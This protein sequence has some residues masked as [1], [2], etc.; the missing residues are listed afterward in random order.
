VSPELAIVAT[1]ARRYKPAMP[2]ARLP[3]TMLVVSIAVGAAS[4]L[5]PAAAAALVNGAPSLVLGVSGRYTVA[6]RTEHVAVIEDGK[7][8]DVPITN[9]PIGTATT[10]AYFDAAVGIATYADAGDGDNH[11]LVATQEQALHDIS[12]GK[13]SLHDDIVA[14]FPGKILS[15]AG[16]YSPDDG[17]QHAIVLFQGGYISDVSWTIGH[18]NVRRDGLATISS[19]VGVGAFYA[20]DDHTRI[21][22]VAEIG[23]RLHEIYYKPGVAPHDSIIATLNET[24]VA[25]ASVFTNDDKYRHA[26]VS[27]L[28]GNVYD[29]FY[30]PCCGIQQRVLATVP[31]TVRLGA[32]ATPDNYRHVFAGT[33]VGEIRELY[34]NRNN[35]SV[36]VARERLAPNAAWLEDVSPNEANAKRTSLQYPSGRMVGVAGDG[37][38]IYGVSPGAGVW[39]SVGGGPFAQ[40]RASPRYSA[41]IASDP[42]DVRHVFVGERNGLAID[43]RAENTGL[44]ESSDG[45]T[46]FHIAFDAATLPECGKTRVITNVAFSRNHSVF[47]TTAC[48]VVRRKDGESAFSRVLSSPQGATWPVF[49]VLSFSEKFAGPRRVW[50]RTQD[51]VYVSEKDGDA[52]SW[53]AFP[54]QK[55]YPPLTADLG[56][57]P[58]DSLSLATADTLAFVPVRLSNHSTTNN[59]A[60]LTLD[61]TTG[62]WRSQDLGIRDGTGLGGRHQIKSILLDYSLPF[63]PAPQTLVMFNDGQGIHIGKLATNGT[64]TFTLITKSDWQGGHADLHNDFWDFMLPPTFGKAGQSSND[65]YYLANDGG[66]ARVQ[67]M[68]AIDMTA[69]LHTHAAHTVTSYLNGHTNRPGILYPTADNDAWW[70]ASSPLGAA[71][72][73][74]LQTTREGDSTRSA[75][76]RANPHV[77]FILRQSGKPTQ[78][79]TV[80]CGGTIIDFD[81]TVP[82]LQTNYAHGYAIYD[83]YETP[84][85]GQLFFTQTIDGEA[86]DPL[87]DAVMLV[88][89]PPAWRFPVPRNPNGGPILLRSR[90]FASYASLKDVIARNNSADGYPI[91]TVEAPDLPYNTTRVYA[92]GGHAQPTYFAYTTDGKNSAAV[93]RRKA[94]G[95]EKLGIGGAVSPTW[96]RAI[97]DI[98]TPNDIATYGPVFVNPYDP[99]H[100]VVATDDGVFVSHADVSGALVF[101]RENTLTA[102]VTNGPEYPRTSK[103]LGADESMVPYGIGQAAHPM[104][105][106]TSVGFSP[107]GDHH[108]MVVTSPFTGAFYFDGTA[109]RSLT[110]VLPRPLSSVS[111]ATIDYDA[112]TIATEGRG[113]L[114]VHEPRKARLA[115]FFSS[116]A[117]DGRV[118]TLYGGPGTAGTPVHVDVIGDPGKVL[119]SVTESTDSASRIAMPS[120]IPTNANVIVRLRYDGDTLHAPCETAFATRAPDANPMLLSVSTSGTGTVDGS[121]IHCGPTCSAG[122]AVNAQ[123]TLTATPAAGWTFSSWSGACSGS[124]AT[125]ILTMDTAKNVIATF[126]PSAAGRHTLTVNVVPCGASGAMGTV[127]STPAGIACQLRGGSTTCRANFDPGATVTLLGAPGDATTFAGF[128]GECS[129]SSTT[130]TI[131]M[132]RDKSVT[133]SFCGRII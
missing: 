50:A 128:A 103:T 89:N 115:C 19:A 105:Y 122:L 113:I 3:L 132:D 74:W 75:G 43:T 129:S 6:D 53:K 116:A 78:D 76:D 125:C 24:L 123:V 118:A 133:V 85:P 86:S 57:S 9:G 73:P 5:E 93:Y 96:G 110:D 61:I 97:L 119:A 33:S 55:S 131:T 31:Q 117:S 36:S 38:T 107:E 121:G 54:I 42:K 37:N 126:S 109:W 44:W 108:T 8:I 62:K 69:G 47:A 91:W 4:F 114:R 90:R 29:V 71:S 130:C 48:G 32:I 45:G 51:M 13:T 26:F 101:A 66:I 98:S 106:V 46:T 127:T 79:C 84:Y 21:V 124:D 39:K 16:F 7:L 15:I 11:A 111:E 35:A 49:N 60:V 67:G 40:L 120:G 112:V 94:S 100:V 92:S 18:A 82:A 88:P 12:W 25:A 1:A 28:S 22:H 56:G 34:F 52:G 58:G 14:S 30:N 63:A 2:I 65:A 72:P 10:L 23:G 41:F 68:T 80:P 83:Q 70:R 99:T 17:R 95:W 102:L 20:N 104:G 27:G 87:L 64:L 81:H 59:C 77:G